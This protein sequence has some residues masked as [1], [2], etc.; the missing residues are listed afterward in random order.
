MIPRN[1][2]EILS[3]LPHFL[4]LGVSLFSLGFVIKLVLS[5]FSVFLDISSGYIKGRR[6]NLRININDA[7]KY[8]NKPYLNEFI[9]V[10][11]ILVGYLKFQLI[12]YSFLDG[13]FVLITLILVFA[14]YIL[15]NC[16]ASRLKLLETI[17]LPFY[18]L[19]YLL[20]RAA[21]RSVDKIVT[22]VIGKRRKN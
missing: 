21:I 7:T 4:L 16:F 17:I 9:R 10:I 5:L 18:S 15:L 12:S 20:P 11:I 1:L 13:E 2:Y 6:R 3:S 22:A 14:S 8:N 19:I